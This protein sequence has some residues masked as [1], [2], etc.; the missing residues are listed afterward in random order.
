MSSAYVATLVAAPQHATLSDAFLARAAQALPGYVESRW[1]DKGVAADL[2]FTGDGDFEAIRERLVEAAREIQADAILQPLAT[3]AKKLLIADMDSTLIGQECVD[4]LAAAIGIG[5]HVAAIT[6]R[7]MRGEIEFE[8]ALR[9]RVGLLAELPV[10]MIQRVLDARISLNPGA[11]TLVATMRARGGYVAIVSGGFTPFTGE[12]ARRLGA[13]EHRA[14]RLV[15]DGDKLSGEV[16]EP[17]LGAN[18]KLEAL[19]DLTQRFGLQRAETLGVGDGAND[20]AMLL[21]AGLGV[22]YYAKPKV[23]AAAHARVDHADLTALL[24]AQGISRAEFVE[25]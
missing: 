6:E 3:R 16:I 1:L 13:D 22:A 21:E 2:I 15:I 20:L 8:S 4:E 9:E 19:R 25:G 11:K 5:Q 10:A 23:A 24:Y 14:N 7:A 17:I 18:A 12:V